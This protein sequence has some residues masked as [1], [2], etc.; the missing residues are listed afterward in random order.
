MQ[1]TY[2]SSM[3]AIDETVAGPRHPV[4]SFVDGCLYISTLWP[5][6]RLSFSPANRVF[7]AAALVIRACAVPSTML[8][9]ANSRK[10]VA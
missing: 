4:W 9:I 10:R 1:S 7:D 8:C 3:F 5:G 6:V 2:P